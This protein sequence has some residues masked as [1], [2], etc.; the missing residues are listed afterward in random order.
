MLLPKL[1]ELGWVLP[2]YAYDRMRCLAES[3]HG[4]PAA[5]NGVAAYIIDYHSLEQMALR[6]S[7]PVPFLG[8]GHVYK[9]DRQQWRQWKE[10]LGVNLSTPPPNEDHTL[11]PVGVKRELKQ[12][13]DKD[14]GIRAQF[15]RLAEIV[16]ATLPLS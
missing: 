14:D 6:A 4:A 15:E 16:T 7:V 10:D 2:E 3:P 5:V 9:V 1:M 12:Q 8:N 11:R 13:T